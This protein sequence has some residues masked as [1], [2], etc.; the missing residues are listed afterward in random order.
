MSIQCDVIAIPI[1]ESLLR[2]SCVTY[3]LRLSSLELLPV[4]Y[5]WWAT[6]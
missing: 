1:I 4:L 6:V 5:S 3:S 2:E